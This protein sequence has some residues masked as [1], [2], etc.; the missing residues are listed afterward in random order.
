M[1]MATALKEI[2]TWP[3]DDQLEFVQR[4]WDQ[5]VS[6]G[7]Q[8]TLTEEQKAELDRRVAVRLI[9]LALQHA[10]GAGEH[11]G[12]RRGVTAAII[13]ARLSQFFSE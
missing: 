9:G 5:L 1:D 6:S 10:I 3:A 8:P 2:Q 13:H 12:H 11:D 4:A 7:W